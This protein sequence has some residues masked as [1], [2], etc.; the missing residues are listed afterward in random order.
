MWIPQ[1]RTLA[2][3]T[4][5]A[6]NEGFNSHPHCKSHFSVEEEFRTQ[7]RTPHVEEFGPAQIYNAIRIIRDD[8]VPK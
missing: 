2:S 3:L 5:G 8:P 4:Q 6:G 7:Y 1:E